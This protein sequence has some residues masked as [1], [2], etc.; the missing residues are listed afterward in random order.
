M[1]LLR[2]MSCEK[3]IGWGGEFTWTNNQSNPIMSNIDRVLVTTEWELK[4]PTC[5]LT[6]LT[7][8]GSDHNP[9]LLDTGVNPNKK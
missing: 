3:F 2:I 6:S 9:I 5:T 7:R 4:Y 8:I 1:T